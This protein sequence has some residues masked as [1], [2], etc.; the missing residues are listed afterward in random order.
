MA[1]LRIETDALGCRTIWLDRPEK[2]NALDEVFLSEMLRAATDVLTDRS[3]RVL[4]V[5]STSPIFSAGADLND[6]A[7]VTPAEAQRLSLLGS[8]AFQQLA[9]LPVPVVAVLEG[10][11][12]GGGFELAL[13]ADIRIAT[14]DAR[15]GFPEA[16]LGNT[17]AWGGVP[18]L[19]RIA[20]V[21]TAKNMLLTG[22]PLSAAQAFGVGIVQR[23][24]EAADLS[25]RLSELTESLL[26]CEGETQGFIK[27]M[28]GNSDMLVAAQEASLAGFTA[29]RLE[30]SKRKE[31]FLASRRR[32]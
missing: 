19:A 2:R 20:G 6:W 25:A 12:L 27:S 11:A 10:A 16:R 14:N 28:F 32:A 29:T 13:A 4:V 8:Q 31:A 23:L 30:A 26:A 1:R 15:V 17:P 7:D 24:C 21:G 3:V 9:D 18:R 22:D 5:R